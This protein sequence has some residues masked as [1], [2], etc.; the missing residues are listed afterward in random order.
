MEIDQ[1]LTTRAAD[2]LR[3]RPILGAA[4]GLLGKIAV[5]YR[6]APPPKAPVPKPPPRTGAKA[7]ESG[8]V[9]AAPP[10]PPPM[11]SPWNKAAVAKRAGKDVR[12]PDGS[13][14][15]AEVIVDGACW[16]ALNEHGRT[17]ALML[18]LRSIRHKEGPDGEDKVKIE[19]APIH[20]WPDM[21][22]EATEII[23]QLGPDGAEGAA[24]TG[25]FIESDEVEALACALAAFRRR[26]DAGQNLNDKAPSLRRLHDI[27]THI[28]AEAAGNPTFTEEV[29][30][31]GPS[32]NGPSADIERH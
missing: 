5:R 25:C 1:E 8:E 11:P 6:P 14:I 18:A 19:K 17:A 28:A 24:L 26:L 10:G 22:N 16:E 4:A 20:C 3:T 30:D 7:E 21:T 15:A 32:D 13:P 9:T 27:L 23:G 31:D 12:F 29:E 2:L